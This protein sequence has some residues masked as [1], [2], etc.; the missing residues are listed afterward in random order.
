[1]H[2]IK[3]HELLATDLHDDLPV[4]WLVDV[5]QHVFNQEGKIHFIHRHIR[6]SWLLQN[7]SHFH[8]KTTSRQSLLAC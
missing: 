5:L 7:K 3:Y 8:S 4:L 1:M 6:Q 2:T